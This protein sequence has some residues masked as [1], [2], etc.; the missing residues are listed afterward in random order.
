MYLDVTDRSLREPG[1][2]EK[3][4]VSLVRR[5]EYLPFNS[6]VPVHSVQHR[7]RLVKSLDLNIHNMLVSKKKSL[8]LCGGFPSSSPEKIKWLQTIINQNSSVDGASGPLIACRLIK[9]AICESTIQSCPKMEPENFSSNHR[10]IV[11]NIQTHNTLIPVAHE[12]R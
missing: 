11:I 1:S 7:E 6:S 4:G 2:E 8:D 3:C 9:G 12:S 5:W 10:Y